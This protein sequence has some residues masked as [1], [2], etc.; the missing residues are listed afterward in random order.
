VD[1]KGLNRHGVSP[2]KR[3]VRF[4]RRSTRYPQKAASRR[5]DE[6]GSRLNAQFG[7]IEG[8]VIESWV[9]PIHL[10]KLADILGAALV[11][12]ENFLAGFLQRHASI[13]AKRWTR[14]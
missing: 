2:L 4:P 12:G 1:R 11:F 10:V 8:Q 14:H 3:S 5:D 9:V 6:V 7:D 13:C